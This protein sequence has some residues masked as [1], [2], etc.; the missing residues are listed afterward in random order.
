MTTDSTVLR[1]N[2]E[3]LFECNDNL[4]NGYNVDQWPLPPIIMPFGSVDAPKMDDFEVNDSPKNSDDSSRNGLE[5]FACTDGNRDCY[6]EA[7]KLGK[8]SCKDG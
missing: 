8:Q 7:E 2:R 6:R 5:C 1:R 3:S 4:C